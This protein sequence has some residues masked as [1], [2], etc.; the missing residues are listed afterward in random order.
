MFAFESLANPK[1]ILKEFNIIYFQSTQTPGQ[2]LS[3]A[4]KLKQP[5]VILLAVNTVVFVLLAGI[6][7]LAYFSNTKYHR[8]LQEKLK[9]TYER[10]DFIQVP[11]V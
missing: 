1:G 3:M 10:P 7:I 11:E 9:V 8:A 5:Q 6:V 4:L 2:T